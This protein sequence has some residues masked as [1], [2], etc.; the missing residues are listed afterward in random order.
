MLAAATDSLRQ[1]LTPPFRAVLYKSLGLT[2]LLLLLAWAGLDKLAL[3]VVVVDHP[4]LHSVLAFATGAGLIVLLAFLIGPISILVAGFFVDDLAAIV[5]RGVYAGRVGTP[6][7]AAQA[8]TMALRFSLVSLGVNLIALLLLLVPG[9]NIVAFFL[10]NAYLFG[11]EYFVLAATRFR[12]RRDAEDLRAH[13][14]FLIFIAGL[15]IAVFVA[16][17]GLNLLTPLFA[18]AFMVRV[19]KLLSPDLARA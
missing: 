5:E 11:R 16:T 8:M 4:L 10:A 6:A 7:P 2:L 3:S 1:I 12:S 9:V 19:H 18:T 17:P 15:F 14:S 13:N